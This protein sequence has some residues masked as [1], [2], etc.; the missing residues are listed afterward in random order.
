MIDLKLLGYRIRVLRAQK[1]LSQ[2]KLSEL[3]GLNGKYLGEVERGSANISIINLSK[4][5]DALAVPLLS[6]LSAERERPRSELVS[7]LHKLIDATDDAQLKIIYRVI[8]AVI[9]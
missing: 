7:E 8:E 2:D 6:L 9:R 3:A 4:L 1:G 5:A